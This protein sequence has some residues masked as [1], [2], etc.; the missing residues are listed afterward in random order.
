MSNPRLKLSKNGSK[1]DS[2]GNE[3]IVGAE[4][5]WK[6]LSYRIPKVTSRL[7]WKKN[8]EES[9]DKIILQPFSGTV[10]PN[11]VVAVMGSSGAGKTTFLNALSYQLEGGIRDGNVYI[12]NRKLT[13]NYFKFV[14]FKFF[15]SIF[16]LFLFI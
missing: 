1:I 11:S 16:F 15:T 12:N 10:R 9:T 6:N 4:V 3:E 14:F 13:R 2:F 7:P 8:K 5:T